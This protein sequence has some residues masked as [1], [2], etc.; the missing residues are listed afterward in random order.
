MAPRPYVFIVFP[1]VVFFVVGLV[2]NNMV[3]WE[4]TCVGI[5]TCDVPLQILSTNTP[6]FSLLTGDFTGFFTYLTA[7][8]LTGLGSL[9]SFILGAIL[10]IFSFVSI[11]SA[12]VLSTGGSFG[13]SDQGAKMVQGIGVGLLVWGTALQFEGAWISSLPLGLGTLLFSIFTIIFVIGVWTQT[14]VFV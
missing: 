6:L 13:I 9:V 7:P 4:T 2:Y 5:M 14:Q 12:Q 8:T 11:A 3:A 10:L 1:L